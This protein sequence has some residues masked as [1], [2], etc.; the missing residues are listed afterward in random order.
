[1]GH[2]CISVKTYQTRPYNAFV[3]LAGFDALHH[4]DNIN[5]QRLFRFFLEIFINLSTVLI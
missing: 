3:D 2:S 1:M 5:E 4:I